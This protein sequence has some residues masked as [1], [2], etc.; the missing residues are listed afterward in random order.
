[1]A[2]KLALDNITFNHVST[3]V[4]RAEDNDGVLQ[5]PILITRR[6][7]EDYWGMPFNE[8]AVRTRI[9]S[10]AA[11]LTGL[12]RKAHSAGISKLI[13]DDVSRTSFTNVPVE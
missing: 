3:A 13:L 11:E 12:A 4:L 1:M 2:I 9:A 10:S 6:F 7:V 5:M 8:R